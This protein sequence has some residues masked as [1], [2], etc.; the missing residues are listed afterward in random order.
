MKMLD[1][2]A[3]WQKRAPYVWPAV[4]GLVVGA[5]FVVAPRTVTGGERVITE[6]ALATPGIA[7]LLMLAAVRFITAVSSYSTGTPGGIFAPILSLAAC[8]GLAFGQIV[9]VALPE[10]FSGMGLTPVSFGI[11]A[12]AALFSASVR[13]PAVGVVLV[14]ELTASYDLTLP[15]LAACLTASLVAQWL[16]GR[17][18]YAQMLERTLALSGAAQQPARGPSIGLAADPDRP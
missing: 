11:V 4:V 18:I 2:A 17:P 14:M 9:Q 7:V 3:A 10:A 1:V 5:L 16:G 13:S 8:L 12:M 6:I 15:T